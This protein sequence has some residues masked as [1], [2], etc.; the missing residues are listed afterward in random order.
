LSAATAPATVC[1]SPP[2][3]HRS[4][5]SP[6][7]PVAAVTARV[8]ASAWNRGRAAV[9][10]L[11]S[12]P[13]SIAR[14]NA[15]SP[16]HAAPLPLA[17]PLPHQPPPMPPSCVPFTSP[18]GTS[19]EADGRREVFPGALS[20]HPFSPQGCLIAG[21]RPPAKTAAPSSSTSSAPVPRTSPT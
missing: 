9:P 7:V 2:R 21:S 19:P 5:R 8:Y 16:F 4:P 20:R 18:H 10:Y 12:S 6:R 1:Q 3:T 17:V 14:E 13:L 15:S 11:P